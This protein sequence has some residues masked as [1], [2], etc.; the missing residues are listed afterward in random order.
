MTSRRV[1]LP[2]CILVAALVCWSAS[3]SVGQSEEQAPML[4][5]INLELALSPEPEM[6]G[7]CASEVEPQEKDLEK[8][9]GLFKDLDQLLSNEETEQVA[10]ECPGY[11]F[12]PTTCS[13][14]TAAQIQCNNEGE[15]PPWQCGLCFEICMCNR[16][17]CN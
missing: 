2:L 12:A 6:G 14:C 10:I 13:G 3:A 5:A 7:V 11:F 4:P 16:G 9:E 8:I 15:L 1:A 17:C